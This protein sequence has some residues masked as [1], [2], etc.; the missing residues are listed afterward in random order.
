M[1][2]ALEVVAICF[3]IFNGVAANLWLWSWIFAR[4]DKK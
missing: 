3:V 1:T 4:G 2:E